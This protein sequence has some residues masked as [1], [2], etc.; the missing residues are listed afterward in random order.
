MPSSSKTRK[1]ILIADDDPMT[2]RLVK[3]FLTNLGYNVTSVMDGN[4]ALDELKK[5]IFD[6]LIS[7]IEMPGLDGIE[8][9][10]K[11]KKMGDLHNLPI[12]MIS[13][14]NNISTKLAAFDAL[15][16]DYIT[17]PFFFDELAARIK[18]Q[19][20]IKQLQEEVQENNRLL[21]SRNNELETH[22]EIAKHIQRKLMPL[23]TNEINNVII[24]SFYRPIDEVGGD[25]FD[26]IPHKDG[27]VSIF[28]GDV[29]GHG[30]PAAFLNIILRMLLHSI[31]KNNEEM[32]PSRVL[33]E[34]NTNILDYIQNEEFITAF[35][36]IIDINQN[37]FIYS[38]AGNPPGLI[39]RNKGGEVGIINSK[40]ICLG[41][42]RNLDPAENVIE[43]SPGDKIILFTDGLIEIRNSDGKFIGVDGLHNIVSK[44]TDNDNEQDIV[45]FILN[46]ADEY[47]G[48]NNYEDD[49]TLLCF[50][51]PD[52]SHFS[53]TTCQIDIEESLNV[54]I[55]PLISRSLLPPAEIKKIKTALS[56]CLLNAVD[57][58]N[59]DIPDFVRSYSS[60]DSI[61][62]KFKEKRMLYPKYANKTIHAKY[63]IQDNKVLYIIRDEGK[64]FDYKKV[65]DPTQPENLT[66][67]Y[68]RGLAL[69]RMI[70]DEV[71][72]NNKGTEI[73]LVKNFILKTP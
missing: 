44:L 70:M 66:R 58:G 1:N 54:L 31:I 45:S 37:R 21:N 48:H 16:D 60:D 6:L 73:R 18:T 57:H 39:R 71:S 40:G 2:H 64:G 36:G 3:G 25:I 42:T 47:Q 41:F 28:I 29:S 14:K 72:F 12:I 62:D 5:G 63:L 52:A 32:S 11:I 49:V 4:D 20:R 38:S 13:A 61:Y 51:I 7:D 69:I 24:S 43:L 34:I 10:K 56:E 68:G 55:E 67:S 8:L 33:E 30:V 23:D 65:A 9:I 15:A 35:Y 17:K 59:L 46:K 50:Q 22:L 27:K 19:L 53:W 26:I